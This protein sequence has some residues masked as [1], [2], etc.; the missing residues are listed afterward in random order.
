MKGG[1]N[2]GLKRNQEQRVCVICG[3]LFWFRLCYAKRPWKA[4]QFC[5]AECRNRF[6]VGANN[7][8]AGPNV[9]NGEKVVQF[10]RQQRLGAQYR[11]SAYEKIIKVHNKPSIACFGCGCSVYAALQI[12]HIHGVAK[13]RRKKEMGANLSRLVLAL[14]DSEVKNLFDIRCVV[15]NWAHHI[16]QKFGI[17]YQIIAERTTQANG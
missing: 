4:G 10:V 11:K 6:Q 12:N 17:K 8:N 14:A 2:K 5:S 9:H 1:W 16:E 7:P 15:C 3:G 13:E